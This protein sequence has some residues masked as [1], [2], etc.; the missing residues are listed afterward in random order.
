M[1][2]LAIIELASWSKSSSANQKYRS[3]MYIYTYI[4]YVII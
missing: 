3:I 2:K 1:S 4:K